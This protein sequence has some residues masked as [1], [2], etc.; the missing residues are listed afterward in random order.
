MGDLS[1]VLFPGY[2]I[3]GFQ[4]IRD[5]DGRKSPVGAE[6]SLE[7]KKFNPAFIDRTRKIVSF[8]LPAVKLGH[9]IQLVEIGQQGSVNVS[10]GN[11]SDEANANSNYVVLTPG[12]H[13][14]GFQYVR[15][16]NG[17][18][19]PIGA[20]FS[21]GTPHEGKCGVIPTI[22]HGEYQVV[23]A[24]VGNVATYHCSPDYHMMGSGLLICQENGQWSEAPSCVAY[25]KPSLIPNGRIVERS[26]TYQISPIYSPPPPISTFP[27]AEVYPECDKGF[28]GMGKATCSGDGAKW[29]YETP[30]CDTVE[31]T[32]KYIHNILSPDS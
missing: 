27:L 26:E 11:N 29:E 5:S 17:R 32:G 12:Y 6:F 9:S 31:N 30:L 28:E 10:M 19:S 8:S 16:S 22:S 20:K 21:V 15:V 7:V 13:I 1:Y 18:R 2:D 24:G 23:D 14:Y 3:Y 4:Y 25:C